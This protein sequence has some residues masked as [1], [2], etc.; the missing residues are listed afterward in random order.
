MIVECQNAE[1]ESGADP[2]SVRGQNIYRRI[3]ERTS[4]LSNDDS[5]QVLGERVETLRGMAGL[6]SG[7]CHF[8]WGKPLPDSST[9]VPSG[10]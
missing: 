3:L 5:G 10:V 4:K 1:V 8:A 6:L 2:E 7:S 9:E